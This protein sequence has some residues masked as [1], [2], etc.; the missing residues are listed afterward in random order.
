MNPAASIL[1]IIILL[2]T[3]PSTALACF[4]YSEEPS[5]IYDSDLVFLG[6]VQ[7]IRENW[8]PPH[9]INPDYNPG[10]LVQYKILRPYHGISSS[11][12]FIEIN[13]GDYRENGFFEKGEIGLVAASFW[14]KHK[15]Y[16]MGA[17]NLFKDLC[18]RHGPYYQDEAA[19]KEAEQRFQEPVF[20]RL[21]REHPNW[22]LIAPAVLLL[23]LIPLWIRQRRKQ[24]SHA[25]EE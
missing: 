21:S 13:V 17:G 23:V 22:T 12:E 20:Q 24:R 10:I 18:S 16:K 8:W 19:M 15:V 4:G 1:L 7:S 2:I 25:L 3:Q 14:K 9:P 6:E 5:S 11:Q